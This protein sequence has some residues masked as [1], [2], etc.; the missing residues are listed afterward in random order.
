MVFSPIQISANDKLTTQ[1]LNNVA[2][3]Y[4]RLGLKKVSYQI[5]DDL[6]HAPPCRFGN[7][8]S[9]MP[10]ISCNFGNIL[11][12]GSYYEEACQVCS[13]GIQLCF[14]TGIITAMPELILQLSVLHMALG[15]METANTLFL[16]GKKIFGWSRK[17]QLQQTLE[18]IMDQEF[19]L[20]CNE[21]D[22]KDKN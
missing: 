21:T 15:H 20:Y 8:R 18:E 16:Y 9:V 13:Q 3:E 10:I 11:R 14:E 6:Y 7:C 2:V 22:E 4:Y 5:W 17:I 19:L 1:T 12:Q